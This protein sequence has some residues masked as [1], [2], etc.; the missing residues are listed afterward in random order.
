[1][2]QGLF[3]DS[4]FFSG[5]LELAVVFFGITISSASVIFI[6][7]SSFTIQHR[8]IFTLIKSSPNGSKRFIISKIFQ[9]IFFLI[10]LLILLFLGLFFFKIMELNVI[11]SLLIFVLIFMLFQICISLGIYLINPSDNEE[12]LTNFINVMVFYLISFFF[13]S[14]PLS[15]VITG[16][17]F[18]FLSITIWIGILTLIAYFFIIIGINSFDQ[19]DLET[20]ESPISKKIKFVVFI[21]IMQLSLWNIVPLL[22]I[23]ILLK[24]NNLFYYLFICY[25]SI[26]VLNLYFIKIRKDKN[27]P[28]INFNGVKQLPMYL[29]ALLAMAFVLISLS[30]LFPFNFNYEGISTVLILFNLDFNETVIL[31][32]LIV[33]AE[34]LFFRWYII[35]LSLEYFTQRQSIL[36]SAMLFSLFHLNHPLSII[37]ALFAGILLGHVRLKYNSLFNCILIHFI[38]NLL[39]IYGIYSVI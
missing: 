22:Y 3:R 20:L 10:P 13:S 25:T 32:F 14:I 33:I 24:T 8:D 28:N 19:M 29:I 11:P 21:L 34:E 7:V 26:I 23:T 4:S 12:D 36:L 38:Y 27:L 9:L 17:S 1:S 16:N 31:I 35:S 6:E 2:A 39:I 15:W 30:N 5:D 37:N 18:T